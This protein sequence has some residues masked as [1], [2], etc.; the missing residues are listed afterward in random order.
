MSKWSALLL[1]ALP[2]RLWA[3]DVQITALPEALQPTVGRL[4]KGAKRLTGV[5]DIGMVPEDLRGRQYVTIVRGEWD[6]PGAGYSFTV[7]S[8]VTVYLAVQ[9]RGKPTLPGGWEQTFYRLEY[10]VPL[11]NTGGTRK[12]YD[13]L[14]KKSF[15]AGKI[16]VPPHDGTDGKY[17]GLPHLAIIEPTGQPP[18]ASPPKT[19][20]VATP[21]PKTAPPP[22]SPLQ[23][24]D[25]KLQPGKLVEF[26]IPLSAKAWEAATHLPAHSLK[27]SDKNEMVKVCLAVPAG[28][29][30]DKSW[31]VIVCNSTDHRPNSIMAG[32]FTKPGTDNGWVVLSADATPIPKEDSNAW[33]WALF[34]TALEYLQAQWPGMAKWPVA[35]GGFSGGAKRS[36][37]FRRDHDAVRLSRH[38]DVDGRLQS[39]HGHPRPAILPARQRLQARPRLPQQRQDRQRRHTK[40]SPDGD[41]FAEELRFPQ[42]PPRKLQRRPQTR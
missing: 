34:A 24:P 35:C 36:G 32:Y 26:K 14:Y 20:T 18:V 15:P 11:Q 29:M 37:F 38:R 7:N 16:E 21:A 12:H 40:P 10:I 33:R 27:S 13:S 22:S 3:A 41:D 28:F 4:E 8:A 9:E 17:Y 23:L 30:P 42:G 1:L 6:K 31:P 2:W 19:V 25:A 39:G 5:Y